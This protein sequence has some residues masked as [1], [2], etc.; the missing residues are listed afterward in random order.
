[1][2]TK[3]SEPPA[4]NQAEQRKFSFITDNFKCHSNN[5]CKAS[6]LIPSQEAIQAAIQ[7]V[8]K[9][10]LETN[11]V[12]IARYQWLTRN[13]FDFPLEIELPNLC[14][15]IKD[16]KLKRAF[17]SNVLTHVIKKQRYFILVLN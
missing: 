14:L 6:R 2:K 3:K 8:R 1:M 9:K 5:E 7:C 13:H 16:G 4:E 11:I 10:R 12:V 17:F 15:E